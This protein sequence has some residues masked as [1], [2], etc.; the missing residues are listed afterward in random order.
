MRALFGAGTPKDTAVIRNALLLVIQ[1]AEA[2]TVM[3]VAVF[4]ADWRRLIIAVASDVA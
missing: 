3:I 4:D 2:I 1:T